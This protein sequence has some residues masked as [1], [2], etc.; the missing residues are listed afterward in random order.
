MVND[1]P[2]PPKE[3][4]MPRCPECGSECSV[5]YRDSIGL[6]IGCDQCIDSID[7]M[8]YQLSKEDWF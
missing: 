8:D 2:D 5:L 3:M 6:I 1:Y 4:P 7:A